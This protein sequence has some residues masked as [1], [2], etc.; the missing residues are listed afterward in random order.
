MIEISTAWLAFCSLM[1]FILMVLL[2]ICVRL[3]LGAQYQRQNAEARIHHQQELAEV[4]LDSI[5]EAVITTDTEHNITYMNPVACQLTGWTADEALQLPLEQVVVIVSEADHAEVDSTLFDCLN[6]ECL[7]EYSEPMLLIGAHGEE[8]SIETSASPLKDR[9]GDI[10]GAVLVFINTSHIRNL[11]RELEFQASHDSLTNLLNRREFERQLAQVIRSANEDNRKH[12]LCYLDLDQFKIVNDTCGHMAGDQLLRELSRLM[13]H[14]IRA[15]DCLARLGGDEFGVIAF[16]C[17]IE[18]AVDIANSLRTAIKNFTFTWNKKVFDIGVSIGVVAITKDSGTLQDILRRADASCYIAKDLGRNRI[19]IY[20]END[21][22]IEKRH[23]EIQWLTR[24]QD[25]LKEDRFR[26]VTQKVTAIK[27]GV[28]PPYE[29]LL[30]MLGKEGEIIAPLAFLPAA[31]RYEMMP[32]IDRWIISTAFKNIRCESAG[33]RKIYNINLSGQTLCDNSI[34]KFIR[35]QLNH[36]KISP[37][38]ICFEITETVVISNLGVAIELVNKIKAMGC[39]FALDDFGC[40]LSSFSYLK[41]LPV[42]YLKIDGEFIQNM[43]TDSTDRAI[44]VAINDI[45]LE[46]GLRTVAEYVESK[47]IFDLLNEINVDY[48]QGH[49]IEK[50]KLWC[51]DNEQNVKSIS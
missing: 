9:H 24:I 39:M 26:L 30:R 29:V 46:M 42:D 50:P 27:N 32:V 31:E 21:V 3:L 23:G 15:T 17:S 6:Q 20:A 14:S 11:S 38:I 16:N 43:V 5:G 49:F 2:F 18:D 10:I 4:A 19:H 51:S 7:I 40:G 25:A 36:F 13:P 48:A 33:D 35:D 47:A 45:G 1:I 8:Y 12:A 37:D 28:T 44:V 41:S 22:E 34:V